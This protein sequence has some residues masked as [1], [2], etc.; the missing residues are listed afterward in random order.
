MIA[1]NRWRKDIV[2][3]LGKRLPRGLRRLLVS[4]FKNSIDGVTGSDRASIAK[5]YI[6]GTGIEIGALSSPLR[7]PRSATV[8]YV[9]RMS[10]ADLR[11]HYPELKSARIVNTDIITDGERLEVVENS[12][13]DFVVANHFIEHCQNPIEAVKN[14]LRVLK[15]GGV[16]YLAIPDKRYTFDTDRPVTS[17]EH[18]IKDYEE[19][20]E[21]SKRQ[22]FEE[23]V[24]MV[25]KVEDPKQAEKQISDLLAI[26]YSIHCHV[27]TQAE[28]F[29]L[30]LTLERKLPF[31]FDVEL[32]LK[33]EGECIFVLRRDNPP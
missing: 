16:L 32:F 8:E 19:G 31:R 6:R 2:Y 9:D 11:K 26:D 4:K 18:V 21:T 12:T 33:N 13:K 22:H 29:E 23:W 10:V 20:P 30:I 3:A 25:N 14:M 27:W 7:V 28:M 5:R 15:P 1:S 17:I 24:R